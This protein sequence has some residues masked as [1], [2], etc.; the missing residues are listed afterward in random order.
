MPR[1]CAKGPDSKIS[2]LYW[3]RLVSPYLSEVRR[4]IKT[5][6]ARSAQGPI[7]PVI[8]SVLGHR[9]KM[10]R[11]ALVFLSG[12]ACGSINSYHKKTAALLELM[13]QATLFHD[14]VIDQAATRRG[15]PTI[16]KLYGNAAA[17]LLG[18][19]ILATVME[20]TAILGPRVSI[21]IAHMARQVCGGEIRQVLAR[22]SWSM[23]EDQY[24]NIIKD[25]SAS[26]F[27]TCCRLGATLAGGSPSQ[28]RSLAG[29][30]LNLGMA[31]QIRDDI[32]DL[33]ADQRALG[34][35]AC[36]DI[37]TGTPTLPVISMLNAL[38]TKARRTWIRKLTTGQYDKRQLAQTLRETDCLTY[39]QTK[40]QGYAAKAI[41]LLGPVKSQLAV[42]GL[43]NLANYCI[44]RDH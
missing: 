28:I 8:G 35:P 32:L 2:D 41:R 17:V 25:K 14:D 24:L 37:D 18:D 39:A 4:L 6:L 15:V 19:I 23:T 12:M 36:N 44:A 21:P 30:G 22:N 11:P 1:P 26:F 33:V 7:Q 5:R 16:N 43:V 20:S 9:G 42:L 29:Y 31:F 34:K 40:A 38:D 27:A 3:S 10:I 13:H